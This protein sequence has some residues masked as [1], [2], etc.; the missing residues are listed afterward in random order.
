[1]SQWIFSGFT[2]EYAPDFEKQ[3]AA[4]RQFGMDCIELRNADGVGVA[5][6]T[7]EQVAG[8]AKILRDQ[9]LGVSAVGSPLGKVKLTD[10]LAPHMETARKIFDFAGILNTENI[11]MFSFYAPEGMDWG[12]RRQRTLDAL[13][14]MLDIA[15]Q[16]SVILCHENEAAIYGDTPE[17][18]LDLLE[19]FGGELKCV[20]DMGNFTLEEVDPYRAYHML[21]PYIRYFHIKDALAAGAVVPPGKG[22]AQIRKILLEH[23]G[24]ACAPTLITLEPHLQT[25]DG[26]NALVGGKG[27]DNPYKYPDCETAFADAVTKIKELIRL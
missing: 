12:E 9:G 24:S 26:L 8:Y 21:K 5:Q 16:Y 25:F 14:Q 15:K 11:R 13:G 20:F 27:F 3:V 2:D 18:C 19:Q 10:D 1:M 17:R 6:M 22:E 7:R 23:A 4:A